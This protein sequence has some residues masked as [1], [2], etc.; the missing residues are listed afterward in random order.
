MRCVPTAIRTLS[1]AIFAL[2]FS[3]CNGN[4]GVSPVPQGNQTLAGAVRHH[5]SSSKIQHIVIIVQ[6][7]RSFNNLF[8]GFPGAK[9]VKY[10]YN[11]NGEKITL[12]PIGLETTWD[13]VHDYYD[14]L[15]SCN[16]TGSYPGTDCQMN[17]FDGEYWG[18]GKYS[19]PSCPTPTLRTAMCRTAKP[20]RTFSWASTT[21]WPTRCTRRTSMPAASSRISTSSRVKPAR[22]STTLRVR[23]DAKAPAIK[24]PRLTRNVSTAATFRCALTTIR[25][26]PKWIPRASRG[27]TMHRR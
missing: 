11:T 7:N 12:Q 16:G 17:G 14:F 25:W 27:P 2:L 1:I 6:E 15:Q 23:G 18:C 21:F 4:G 3:A 10:G 19:Y 24:S 5:S 13:I 8:Y 20:N 9:T 26:A 22:R